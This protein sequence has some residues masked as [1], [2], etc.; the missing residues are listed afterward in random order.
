MVLHVLNFENGAHHFRL[1]TQR[2]A[3]AMDVTTFNDITFISTHLSASFF[4]LPKLS[5][6]TNSLI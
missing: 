5:Q 1:I 2:S 4:S 6:I 3:F